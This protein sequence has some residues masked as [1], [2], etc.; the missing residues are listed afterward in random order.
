MP[1][2][3]SGTLEE[4][5]TAETRYKK[6]QVSYELLIDEERPT[7]YDREHR[8]NPMKIDKNSKLLS[9]STFALLD[10]DPI[11]RPVAATQAWI[12]S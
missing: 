8:V 11:V 12:G 3:R 7:Q 5:E 10:L 4:G 1:M 2:K 6:I 9:Y